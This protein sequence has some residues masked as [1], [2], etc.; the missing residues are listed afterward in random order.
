MRNKTCIKGISNELQKIIPQNQDAPDGVVKIQME[1]FQHTLKKPVRIAGV[2]L[3]SGRRVTLNI[4]PAPENSG[5]CFIRKTDAG[6]AVPISAFMANITDTRLATTIGADQVNVSTVEH[7]LAAFAGLEIDNAVVEIDDGEVPILDGSAALFVGVLRKAQRTRQ[8]SNRRMIRINKEVTFADG[9]KSVTVLPSD[10]FRITCEID[11]PH[12][13][14]KQQKY[15]ARIS[16]QRFT[17]QIAPARTFGFLEEIEAL[18]QNGLALGG[19][20]ENAVVVSRFGGVL[21]EDGLRF[22]DEF[23]RHKALDLIGDLALL[24]CPILG[25][26]IARKAGHKQHF[27]FMQELAQST[28]AWEYVSV[29]K[30]GT[31][32]IPAKLL[33][34]VGSQRPALWP[35]LLPRP[36]AGEPCQ[37]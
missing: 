16:P 24:G 11:F 20:L 15:S 36:L 9:D 31:E 18:R 28:D 5:I 32:K 29:R 7:L 1:Q 2:G 27:Q 8:R 26:V 35:F 22:A 30:K 34:G 14:I 13:I 23:V 25:H 37:L 12:E 10:S 4:L 6:K 3:H 17:D 19:S 21:N 33:R